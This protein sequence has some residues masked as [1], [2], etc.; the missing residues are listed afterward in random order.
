MLS[1]RWQVVTMVVVTI[2]LCSSVTS[3]GQQGQDPAAAIASREESVELAGVPSGQ[4]VVTYENAE[5]MIKSHSASLMDVLRAVCAQIGAELE[6]PSVG[7]DVV[8]GVLGPGA[9]SDVLATM[10][11]G[12]PYELATAGSAE[13]PNRV[14]RVVVLPKTKDSTAQDS[15]KP[16]APD[17]KSIETLS[18]STQPTAQPQPELDA[19]LDASVKMDVHQM[20]EI[21]NEAKAEV[22]Q[23]A[24]ETG[25]DLSKLLEE[26]EAHIKATPAANPEAA[27]PQSLPPSVRPRMRH[28]R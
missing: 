8:L 9:V 16:S 11:T 5:L 20:L 3:W 1:V 22:G 18:A 6:A 10:L 26:V 7:D 17:A 4:V 15:N 14:A 12:S 28:R 27:V 2:L 21:L 19:D 13:D 25:V 24:G 23:T